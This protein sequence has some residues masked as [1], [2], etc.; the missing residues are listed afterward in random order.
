WGLYDMH[1]NVNEWCLDGYEDYPTTA[2]IDPNGVDTSLRVCRGGRAG[3]GARRCRSAYRN[4]AGEDAT[5]SSIGFRVALTP[6][7]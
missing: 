1:G 6:V 7:K 3:T 4:T 2:V 5:D